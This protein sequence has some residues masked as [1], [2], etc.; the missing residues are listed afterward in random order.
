MSE[1][2]RCLVLVD[3]SSY[4]YRAFHAMPSLTN[5]KGDPTGAAYGMT[6]MLKRLEAE[7]APEL[8]AVIFDAKGKTFRDDLYA[9]VQGEPPADAHGAARPDRSRS[10]RSC[11][12]SVSRCSKW[13][14]WR[15]TTSSA[16]SRN[17][18]RR[19]GS[20]CSS[21]PA[22]R[23]WPSSW[24]ITSPWSIP[25]TGRSSTRPGWRPSSA[26]RRNPS[27]TISPWSEIRSTTSPGSRKWDPRPPRNGW[28]STGP[29]RTSSTT[30]GRSRARSERTCVRASSR[31]RSRRSW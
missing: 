6:N 24:T 25:W 20:T 21:P 30:P 16:P 8:V 23:T 31:F 29:S 26:C 27:S 5:S 13:G 3:G 11:E 9:A 28:P 4:L 19:Q 22:T 18:A 14:G 7:V 17:A 15:P 1:T 10:M 2:R 12:R